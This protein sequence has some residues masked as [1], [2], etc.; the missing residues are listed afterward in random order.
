MDEVDIRLIFIQL[1]DFVL[2]TYS[3]LSNWAGRMS[4]RFLHVFYSHFV[5]L[6]DRWGYTECVDCEKW[7]KDNG[8]FLCVPCLK[9]RRS[10]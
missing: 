10:S 8:T 3:K 5:E 4:R 6:A 2:T 7:T 1:Y 9:E